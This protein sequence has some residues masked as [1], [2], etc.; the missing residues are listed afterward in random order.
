MQKHNIIAIGAV[1][2]LTAASGCSGSQSDSELEELIGSLPAV[3]ISDG[4]IIFDPSS[5]AEN[6]EEGFSYL[7]ISGKVISVSKKSIT[8]E[9]DK[10][11]FKFAVT[12]DTKTLGGKINVS[13]AV[14]ITYEGEYGEGTSALIITVLSGDIDCN[15]SDTAVI[16]ETIN[17]AVETAVPAEATEA[18]T[19]ESTA[20]ATTDAAEITTAVSTNAAETVTAEVTETTT[21]EAAVSS[22][23]E[24]VGS[25]TALTSST[26]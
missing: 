18:E 17:A 13:E 2:L 26:N 24:T 4:E 12:A 23:S 16:S 6:T 19:A 14:T 20:E 15:G 9:A 8:I 22:V 25:E 10:K 3:Q 11:E 5:G 7:S 1:L 21:E